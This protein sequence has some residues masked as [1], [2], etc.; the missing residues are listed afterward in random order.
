MGY[1]KIPYL[2][3]VSG[4]ALE[5]KQLRDFLIAVKTTL[6][7]LTGADPKSNSALMDLLNA[8]SSNVVVSNKIHRF[9]DAINYT[10]IGPKGVITMHGDARPETFLEGIAITGRGA[11]APTERLDEAP[12]LSFTFVIGNDTHQTFEIPYSMDYSAAAYVKI[13]WYTH[14]SQTDDEVQ[15]QVS[16]SPVNEYGGAINAAPTTVPSGDIACPAQWAIQETLL[17][18]IPGGTFEDHDIIGIEVSRIDI[19]DG[20]DP[21]LNS[22]H[23]LSIEFEYY[24]NKLGEAI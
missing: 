13:H 5:D 19:D 2:P 23:L 22:I 11:S 8:Y 6:E 17:A 7:K 3:D 10:Q 4:L 14:L 21:T 24:M 20:T 1:I 9:G 16:Y 12:F 15:W 18:T